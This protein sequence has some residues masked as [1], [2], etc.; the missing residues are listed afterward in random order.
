MDSANVILYAKWTQNATFTLTVTAD[1]GSVT[2]APSRSSYDSGTV[3]TLMATAAA[4]YRFTGWSG[5]LAGS[6]NPDSVIMT[7]AKSITANFALNT[8]QLTVAAGTG[9]TITAPAS[10]PVTVNHGAATTITAAPA[11]GYT[12]VNWTVTSGTATISGATSA[13]TTVTLSSGNAAVRANFTGNQY[14]VTF[15]GQGATTEAIPA[16]KTV[17]VPATTV[18]TLA[19]P[20]AKTSY[21]FAGW[22]TGQNGAGLP[23]DAG[24]TV[25]A[26]STIYAKWIIQDASGNI[27]TEVEINGKVWMVQNLRTT[28]FNNGSTISN[29]TDDL[30]WSQA[31]GPACCWYP[32]YEN[33]TTLGV[34]YN[35]YASND[36]ATGLAPAGWRVASQ[37]DWLTLGWDADPLK[38]S[39]FWTNSSPSSNSTGFSALAGGCRADTD[40]SFRDINSIGYWAMYPAGSPYRFVYMYENSENVTGVTG[41]PIIGTSV[42]CV[43]VW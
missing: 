20:P 35:G 19:T 18:G 26:N 5:D 39:S 4:G 28:K 29:V 2:K 27:Y 38:H 25:S 15:N 43:R 6:V 42:R 16:T 10:S 8:Y 9:G 7:S 33:N 31:T 14:V 40:G 3:V 22:W 12:F 24:T 36:N 11:A 21:V 32:G 1:N 23:F 34:L 17:T 13:S 41:D 37:A 30:E